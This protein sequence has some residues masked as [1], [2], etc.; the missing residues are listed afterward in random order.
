MSPPKSR[1]AALKAL[2]DA[3]AALETVEAEVEAE[4]PAPAAPGAATSS[5]LGHV[6]EPPVKGKDFL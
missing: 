4:A 2:H 3:E 6:N 5:Y 1:E